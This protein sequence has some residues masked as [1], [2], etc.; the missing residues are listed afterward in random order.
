L[1]MHRQT[2]YL[3]RRFRISSICSL[4]TR[5]FGATSDWLMAIIQDN[6]YLNVNHCSSVF[7]HSDFLKFIYTNYVPSRR[8]KFPFT[9]VSAK[10]AG[11][12]PRLKTEEVASDRSRRDPG[13]SPVL[14][15]IFTARIALT[16]ALFA[17]SSVAA[18][19]PF[20]DAFVQ[21][22]CAACHNSSAPAARL[23][24]TKLGYEPGNPDNFATWV[25]VHDRVS[26]GEMPPAP[27]ARPS[28][29]S[30]AQFVNGLNAALTAYER[31]VST[32]R[33]RAGLRRLNAYEYENSVRDLLNIPWVQIKTKL[34]QDGEAWR[35]NKIGTALDVSHVQ[36]A[37][38]MSSADYA[39]RQ[40]MAAK[41]VQPPS[42]A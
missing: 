27:I 22:N 42:C 26:A 23:D 6:E 21:K 32:E 29:D 24:L 31:A 11:G 25:K 34:P 8:G 39:L 30:L 16:A 2:L 35:Y 20:A 18:G 9:R 15:L 38:S 3:S 7:F 40:A 10:H 37:R 36:L 14:K 19:L 17:A 41:L 33:G 12:I 28:A 5:S 4:A 1:L 13:N